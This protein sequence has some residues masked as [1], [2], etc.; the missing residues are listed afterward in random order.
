[1]LGV[2][3]LIGFGVASS[4]QQAPATVAFRATELKD[5]GASV[6]F[7]AFAVDSSDTE[8]LILLF[9][10]VDRTLTSATVTGNNSGAHTLTVAQ[11]D[12]GSGEFVVLHTSELS[13]DT[14][15]T[16]AVTYN[17]DP[18]QVSF[19]AWAVTNVNITPATTSSLDTSS[20]YGSAGDIPAGGIGIGLLYLITPAADAYVANPS[21]T[22]WNAGGTFDVNIASFDYHSVAGQYEGELT[23]NPSFTMTGIG[24]VTAARY[25]GYTFSPG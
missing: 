6:T 7:T 25:R 23:A 24:T 5:D 15:A 17:L 9:S 14:T 16:I 21:W 20:P 12:A 10:S 19:A 3:Q 22:N 18:N 2:T 11:T 13:G 8:L 4:E 1:M